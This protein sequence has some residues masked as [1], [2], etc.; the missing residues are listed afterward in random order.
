MTS[1]ERNPTH[2]VLDSVF[3]PFS[4]HLICVECSMF[5]K[6][7]CNNYYISFECYEYILIR[8]SIRHI[9]SINR[10]TCNNIITTT[11]FYH[12]FNNIY[13]NLDLN[14]LTIQMSCR[15]NDDNSKK[16]RIFKVEF[17]NMKKIYY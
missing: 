8:M 4:I 1:N 17:E 11:I 10:E 5:M 15:L 7:P 14:E 6:L 12:N 9:F 16:Q 2:S 3:P 13:L